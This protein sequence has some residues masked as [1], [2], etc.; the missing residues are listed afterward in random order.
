MNE[1]FI[2]CILI[3]S[4]LCIYLFPKILSNFGIKIMYITFILLSLILSFKY[5]TLSTLQISASTI[6]YSTMFTAICLLLEKNMIKETKQ[7]INLNVILNIFSAIILYIMATY[8]QSL[9][10]TIG[11]NMT[12]VFINNSRI[13]IVYPIANYI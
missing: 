8:T 4:I 6:T 3:I 5:I 13:L 12:N 7:I 11:I 1:L 9:N 2:L 10:D